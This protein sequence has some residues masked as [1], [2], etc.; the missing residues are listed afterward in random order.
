MT[1]LRESRRR[2]RPARQPVS[3]AAPELKELLNYLR[4]V[5]AKNADIATVH[6]RIRAVERNST[7]PRLIAY[8]KVQT[9][10]RSW[11]DAMEFNKVPSWER[12]VRPWAVAF[13]GEDG[14]REAERLYNAIGAAELHRDHRDPS[15][16]RPGGTKSTIGR[17]G[18]VSSEEYFVRL[19]RVLEGSK[20]AASELD[21]SVCLLGQD[22]A[23]ALAVLDQALAGDPETGAGKRVPSGL[24][25]WGLGPTNA[26]VN[27]CDDPHWVMRRPGRSLQSFH[28]TWA[29]VWPSLPDDTA[30]HYVSL[31]PGTGKKDRIVLE[32]LVGR[33]PDL[34]YVPVDMSV[35]ML[36]QCLDATDGLSPEMLSFPINLDFSSIFSIAEL[37][38]VT[39]QLGGGAPILY[40]LLGNTLANFDDDK[41]LLRNLATLLR[42]QDRLVLEVAV[43]Q[44]LAGRERLAWLEYSGSIRFKEFVTA[45]LRQN[46]DI[47]MPDLSKSVRFHGVIEPGH[48]IRI[49]MYHDAVDDATLRL[50][51]APIP[52]PAGD[53]IRL[54]VSRK[55]AVDGVEAMLDFCALD[56]VAQASSRTKNGFGNL[57]MLL[58]PAGEAA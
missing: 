14:L 1:D 31:G 23:E 15:I 16:S 10:R 11:Q 6:R 43:T 39:A 58:A 35:D 9:F 25:Y 52:F 27:A 30:Y 3:H 40:S 47:S 41:E 48:A 33:Q 26:W 12:V 44:E 55:Y 37:R 32:T 56:L 53:M 20:A 5:L 22:Q 29:E 46:S 4:W 28:R 54:Y 42:P 8:A 24:S 51:S 2:G 50:A 36:K 38:T 21:W 19:A 49:E 13:G 18:S 34:M 57:L 7:D 45:T 17:P